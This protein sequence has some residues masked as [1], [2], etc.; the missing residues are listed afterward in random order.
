MGHARKGSG[1]TG[2]GGGGGGQRDAN[3]STVRSWAVV[4]S[5]LVITRDR[6]HRHQRAMATDTTEREEREKKGKN[7]PTAGGAQHARGVASSTAAVNFNWS[8]KQSLSTGVQIGRQSQ[9]EHYVR[10]VKIRIK[11]RIK[12][13]IKP[14]SRVRWRWRGRSAHHRWWR[15]RRPRAW[16]AAVRPQRGPTSLRCGL[17]GSRLRTK[18]ASEKQKAGAEEAKIP[19]T[20]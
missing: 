2:G 4:K 7:N 11:I 1:Y 8:G 6:Q 16:Q 20:N 17:A 9:A 19:T 5:E 13:R 12:T 14:E 18:W 10:E 3:R 15:R